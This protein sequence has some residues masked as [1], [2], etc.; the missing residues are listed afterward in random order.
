MSNFLC[1][2]PRTSGFEHRSWRMTG[3]DLRTEG[4]HGKTSEVRFSGSFQILLSYSN[5]ESFAL[6]SKLEI[7]DL[8]TLGLTHI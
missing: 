1:V 4:L 2:C 7:T 5:F 6:T 8:Q 3:S